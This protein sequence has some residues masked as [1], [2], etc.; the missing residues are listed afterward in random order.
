MVWPLIGYEGRQV[1]TPVELSTGE[2]A[3]Q[4]GAAWD[5]CLSAAARGIK[6][7]IDDAPGR[8]STGG[9]ITK[10]EDEPCFCCERR[11][12]HRSTHTRP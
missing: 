3:M 10:S 6:I 2:S 5:E 11:S 9:A 8:Y 7:G 12:S 1:A 4:P